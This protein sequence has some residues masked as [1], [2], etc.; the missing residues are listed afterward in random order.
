MIYNYIDMH[1]DSLLKGLED[2]QL[3][4]RPEN[5]LD[6]K[7]ML[8]AGQMAQFFAVFFPPT[9]QDTQALFSKA[10]ALLLDTVAAHSDSIAMAYSAGDIARNRAAGRTSAL[11]TLEDGRIVDG[12]LDRLEELFDAGVRAIALTWNGKNCFGHPNS[13]D[14]QEMAQGLTDFGKA[15]V[16]EMNRLGILI[17]ASHLSD[18]SFWDVLA[19][20]QKP[21]AAT[22]SNCRALCN[23]PR[24]MTDRMLTALGDKGGVVG[25]NFAPDFLTED[26][27]K[28][29]R[30]EDLCRHIL[31][32]LKV[33]G[34]DAVG[35]GTDFDGID[36]DF[37]LGTPGD[38]DRLFDALQ[39]KGL[40]PRQL[41]KFTQGNAL[42]L[43]GDAL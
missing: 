8:S 25:V 26:G 18:G 19:L 34:E 35:L 4:A 21:V 23:H 41:D 15:A 1:C 12:H 9:V 17:D 28:T 2:G 24:N 29:S 39:Q 43:L 13:P 30:L 38:L 6:V 33:A 14:P 42:R 5:M 37:E 20:S 22:H 10:R 32:I 27:L 3:Y 16:G 40:T 7:R 31:H 36:G 11:L